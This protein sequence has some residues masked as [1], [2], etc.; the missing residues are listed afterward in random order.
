MNSS[1]SYI[2]LSAW[3]LGMLVACGS[4]DAASDEAAEAAPELAANEIVLSSSQF[5]SSGMVLGRLSSHEFSATLL[6]NGMVD[7]PPESR[8]AVSAFYGGY[9]RNLELL[10]GQKVRK[11]QVIFSIEN[12]DYVIMQQEYLEA[13]GQLAYLKGDFE[14]QQTLA[15]E[16][17]TSQKNFLK[18]EADYQ[19]T[20]ARFE[21][22]KKQLSLLHIDA[23]AI[24]GGKLQ[25]SAPVYAPI[26]GYLTEVNTTPGMFLNPR[27]VAVRITSTEHIHLELSV[28]EKDILRIKKGQKIRFRLPDNRDVVYEASVFLVG[29]IVE[30]DKRTVNVHA[31]LTDESQNERFVPGM[32]VEAEIIAESRS[33]SA[34][35]ET[36]VVNVEDRYFVLVKKDGQTDM[37]FEKREVK[38]GRLEGGFYEIANA[39]ELGEN[40]TILVQGAFNLIQE[41]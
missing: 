23:A 14:R 24:E 10:P 37:Q 13:K 2:F 7:V 25:S 29:K 1:F 41:E 40:A 21:S 38:V 8:V 36:A 27:D 9:V 32:Y 39:S 31:H 22:L 26:S 28:F 3:L 15:N 17:I 18:A 34:L 11:G 35:P 5:E 16:N 20:L 6:A 12:P 30:P 33:A 4:N 19:V